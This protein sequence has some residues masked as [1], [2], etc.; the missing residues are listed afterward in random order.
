MESE[1]QGGTL[2]MVLRRVT[3]EDG[4]PR[5]VLSGSCTLTALG[6]RLQ[7]LSAELAGYAADPELQWD[8]TGINQMD[9]AGGVLL[10]RAW[11]EHRPRH[12][13]LRPEHER[14]FSRCLL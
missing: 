2:S 11:G 1:N 12:L 7:A 8:L 13:Y 9:D 14:L 4:A 10:W 6:D 5:L 3:G